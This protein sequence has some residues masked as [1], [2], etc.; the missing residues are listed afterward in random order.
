MKTADLF[1]HHSTRLSIV[2]PGFQ[3]FG[4]KAA[5]SGMIYTVKV[6]EDNVLVKQTLGEPGNG[7]VLVVDGGGSKRCALVGDMLAQMAIDH[8]W[9]GIIVYGCIRD[10]RD[11]NQM[12]IGVR[13][14]DTHPAKS[15]KRGEGT[16][17]ETVTF[18]SVTFTSGHYV[19]CDEDGIVVSATPLDLDN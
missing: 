15:I 3:S 6:F 7:R 13:A 12:P 8:D 17:G 2:S 18:G 16:R 10:S 19:Y 1:D 14:L 9:A 5:F 11:I 4:A